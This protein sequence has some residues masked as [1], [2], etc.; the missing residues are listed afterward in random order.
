MI[1][2]ATVIRALLVPALMALLGSTNWWA[3]RPLRL[4]AVR[5]WAHPADVGEPGGAPT[6]SVRAVSRDARIG[7]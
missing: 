1:I 2:D 5:S 4:L 7:A 3:P 6:L